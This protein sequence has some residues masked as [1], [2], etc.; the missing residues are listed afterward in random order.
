[1]DACLGYDLMSDQ[2][3]VIT[4]ISVDIAQ[5][6]YRRKDTLVGDKPLRQTYID[7]DRN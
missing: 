7:I 6:V 3:Q 5:I 1:M 2:Q 4:R